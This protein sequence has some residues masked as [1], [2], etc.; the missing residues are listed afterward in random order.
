LSADRFLT[1][2]IEAGG[3]KGVLENAV[4][5]RAR[6]SP[7]EN[8]TEAVLAPLPATARQ[9]DRILPSRLP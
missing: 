1:K 5:A 6:T 3:R 4:F 2:P 9:I 7:G 8:A